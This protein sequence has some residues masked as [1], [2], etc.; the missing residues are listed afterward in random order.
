MTLIPDFVPNRIGG[1]EPPRGALAAID[2][3]N[4]H[5]ARGLTAI[6]RSGTAEIDAAVA[7]ARA[8]QPGWAAM[9]AVQRGELLGAHR[10]ITGGGSRGGAAS[11]GRR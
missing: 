8:A 1:S 9:P 4:P 5:D 6:P 3:V 2:V 7:A 11:A 10:R